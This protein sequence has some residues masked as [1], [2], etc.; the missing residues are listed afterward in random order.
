MRFLTQFKAN[1]FRL[2]YRYISKQGWQGFREDCAN[3]SVI[4]M[5]VGRVQLRA[6]MYHGDADKPLIVYLHGGGWVIGDTDTYHPFTAT[7]TEVTGCTVVSVDYRLAPEHPYPAALDDSIGSAEWI[8]ENIDEIAPNNGKIVI[9]GDSAGG[10]LASATAFALKD[11]PSVI[12]A[13]LIYPATE[14]YSADF[15][16]YQEHAKAKPLNTPTMRWF[17]DTYLDGMAPADPSLARGLIM[18]QQSLRGFPPSLVVTAEYDPLRDDGKRLAQKLKADG[19]EVEYL[20]FAEE[21]H[22][23]A[24]FSYKNR[25]HQQFLTATKK[26]L[27]R[28]N[29][30]QS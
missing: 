4:L 24:T 25:G 1:L 15:P 12:G 19:V 3:C 14:H 29:Q 11:N 23:F 22:G 10:N 27:D 17:F 28:L 20:H 5:H 21:A 6:R 2:Y 16:S 8:L 13:I 18:R 30:A 7:L 9:A 26:W